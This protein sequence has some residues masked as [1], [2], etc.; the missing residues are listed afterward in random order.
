VKALRA[1]LDTARLEASQQERENRA[2][3]KALQSRVDRA[4][5]MLE[6]NKRQ[7]TVN[8]SSAPMA[9]MALNGWLG[10]LGCRRLAWIA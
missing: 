6:E 1:S 8:R 9:S 4:E 5:K 10:P 3:L 7:L 2:Q